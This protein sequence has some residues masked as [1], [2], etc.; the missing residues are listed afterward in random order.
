MTRNPNPDA[1]HRPETR[2][3]V[4][5][6]IARGDARDRRL[7]RWSVVAA[8]TVHVILFTIHWPS[9]ADA[10]RDVKQ[11][12]DSNVYVVN[13]QRYAP[14]ERSEVSEPPTP[15]VRRVQIPDPDPQAPEPIRDDDFQPAPELPEYGDTIFESP[16]IP[17]PPEDEPI[18]WRRGGK[19]TEPIKVHAPSPVYPKAA[20]YGGVEGAVI[21]RLVI[22]ENGVPADVNVMRGLP[23]GC[24]EA[25]LR[26]VRGW[27]FEPATLDGRPVKVIY[28]L[29]VRFS[30]Q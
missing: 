7:L 20:A 1:D 19:V 30:L 11:D 5:E 9:I 25:A 24:S 16:E 15:P 27:R 18:I 21:L 28:I 8:V 29:T 2:E 3:T 13:I 10:E 22:D 6:I 4:A 23:L 17:A 14:P 26:A 12:E